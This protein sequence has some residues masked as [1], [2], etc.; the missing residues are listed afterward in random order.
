MRRGK[1]QGRG[2]YKEVPRPSRRLALVAPESSQEVHVQWGVIS[3]RARTTVFDKTSANPY[4]FLKTWE[5]V[6]NDPCMVIHTSGSTGLPNPV[7]R[8]HS[9]LSECASPFISNGWPGVYLY[10]GI[11]KSAAHIQHPDFSRPRSSLGNLP[12]SVRR[13]NRCLW[14][15][16]PHQSRDIDQVLW[17]A[18]IGG[19]SCIPSTLEQISKVPEV[20]DKLSK[21]R[22]IAYVGGSYQSFW[23]PLQ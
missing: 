23:T 8:P 15:T 9:T 18:D 4:P 7:M 13:E 2:A 12:C 21:L 22:H 3:V 14:S 11:W 17:H 5:D 1:L 10:S 6:H 16:W 19:A 20:V